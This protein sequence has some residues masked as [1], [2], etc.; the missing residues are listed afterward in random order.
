M[1]RGWQT[2]RPRATGAVRILGTA[3]HI[4][5]DARRQAVRVC[6]GRSDPR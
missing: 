4:F 2:A 5:I 1:P 6:R 3:Q